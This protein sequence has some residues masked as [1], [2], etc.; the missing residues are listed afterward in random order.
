MLERVKIMMAVRLLCLIALGG[1]AL[2]VAAGSTATSVT[3]YGI[4]WHFEEEHEVGQ[5][6]NGDWWV[7]GPVNIREIT[8]RA[9]ILS[10]G[11][12]VNGSMLNPPGVSETRQG[13][14]SH[15][16][17]MAYV[18]GLN[19]APSITGMPLAVTEG[20]I[21]SS[22]SLP[23]PNANGRPLLDVLA[24]LTVVSEKP[25]SGSFRPSPYAES[26]VSR[27]TFDDINLSHLRAL[28]AVS[29]TPDIE[30]LANRGRMFWNE[31]NTKWSQRSVQARQNQPMYGRG[32]AN[33]RAK[34]LLSLHLDIP[35]E[36]KNS[37]VIAAVQ[38]GIDI[39]ERVEAGGQWIPNGGHNAGRKMPMLMA[40]I[41]LESEDI[42]KAADREEDPIR[43]QED[44]QTFFVQAD[45]PLMGD[46]YAE[47][48]IGTPEWGIRHWTDPMRDNP[49]W[50][51][52]YR[53]IGASMVGHALAAYLTDG[54]VE[55][56][57]WD[58]FFAY[59]ERFIDTDER[60]V[61]TVNGIGKFQ[62][63]MW[64]EYRDLGSVS[65][66]ESLPQSR[67]SPPQLN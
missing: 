4:T 41:L 24:V 8:P 64:L 1:G 49:S 25:V 18:S 3:Q 12:V 56:W 47:E 55:Y 15:N 26:K 9:K 33:E 50:G 19:V 30:A 59:I 11:R 46:L 14:D 43:F 2:S 5:Y 29:S 48:D 32:I 42:I 7:V 61:G 52:R 28:P 37:L 13:Y 62:Y 35:P 51:A 21:V 36:I 16:S 45:H 20:S 27:W 58:P 38:Q 31:Q 67:P 66:P 17:D 54:A 10:S 23:E 22:I 39:F 40:G 65:Q 34:L 53:W 63:E 57:N 6:V 44:G 60:E